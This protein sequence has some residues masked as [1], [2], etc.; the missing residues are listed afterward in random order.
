MYYIDHV[1]NVKFP[2]K[3]IFKYFEIIIINVCEVIPLK[4]K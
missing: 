4:T 3:S 1:Y 2:I